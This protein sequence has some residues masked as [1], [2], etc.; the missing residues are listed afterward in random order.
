VLEH[1]GFPGASGFRI[2]LGRDSSAADVEA[3]LA[4][5]P[6]LVGELREIAALSDDSLARLRPPPAR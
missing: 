2:G 3:L 6:G 5:L 4:V 1:T